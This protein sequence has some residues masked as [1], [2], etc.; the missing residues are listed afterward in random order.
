[1][2]NRLVF[3]LL[4]TGFVAAPQPAPAQRPAPALAPDTSWVARSAMYEVFVRDFSS[5][6][7]VSG[8]DRGLA[9][10]PGVRGGC[11]LADADPPDRGPEPEGLAWIAVRGQGLPCRQPGV[12][13][14]RGLPGAGPGGARAK[15]EAHPRLGTQSHGGR[16]LLGPAAPRLVL[17]ERAGR[18]E[19]AARRE[20][21]ADRLDRR[22]AARLRKPRRPA[23]DDRHYALLAGRAR[24]RRLSDGRRRDSSPT[25]SGGTPL[26]ALRGAVRRPI[27][28]L[29][30][31]GDLEMHRAGFDLTYGWDAYKRLKAVW[32]GAPASSFVQGELADMRAMPRRRHADA[33]HHQPRRDRLGPASADPLRRERRRAG[34]LRGRTRCCRVARCS[35]T[36]RRSRVRRSWPCSSGSRSSGNSPGATRPARSTR[37]SSGWPG[38]SPI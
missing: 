35:T 2:L 12:R 11:A 24:G 9:S 18:A 22:G 20:G 37:Q 38:P 4:A 34:G 1:M 14:H 8:G 10:D 26:P 16:P 5:A 23:G 30:E 25:S 19:R 31:W 27:L 33:L 28:L 29:A 13:D 36:A 15:D 3:L 32:G 7:H 6:G 17:P 21:Q